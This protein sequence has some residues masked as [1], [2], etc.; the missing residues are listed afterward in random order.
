MKAD[1]FHAYIALLKQTRPFIGS[2][3]DDTGFGDNQEISMLLMKQVPLIIKATCK[4]TKVYSCN[5]TFL[6]T[7]Y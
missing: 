7:F 3:R 1:I 2:G 5:L 6:S 4:Q